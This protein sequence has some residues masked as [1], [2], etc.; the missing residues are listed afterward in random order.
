[1]TLNQKKAGYGGNTV[2]ILALIALSVL[3]SYF[4]GES[5]RLK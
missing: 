1:M 4:G 5:M 3:L 2:L